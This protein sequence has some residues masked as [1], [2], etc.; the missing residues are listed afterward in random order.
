MLIGIIYYWYFIAASTGIMSTLEDMKQPHEAMGTDMS[1]M[2]KNGIKW[3][4]MKWVTF[5]ADQNF[6]GRRKRESDIRTPLVKN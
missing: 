5:D 2:S 1:D 3:N 6:I 4:C